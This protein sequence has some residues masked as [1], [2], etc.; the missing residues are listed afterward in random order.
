MNQKTAQQ[1]NRSRKV[2][3]EVRGSIIRFRLQRRNGPGVE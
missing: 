1:D 3:P 2:T